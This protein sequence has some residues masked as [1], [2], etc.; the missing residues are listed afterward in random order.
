MRCDGS[1]RGNL[2]RLYRVRQVLADT[3]M[4]ERLD[5]MDPSELRGAFKAVLSA[6]QR[7]KGLDGFAWLGGLDAKA[8]D[9]AAFKAVRKRYW[10]ILTQAKGELPRTPARVDGRRGRVAKSDAQ[11]LHEALTK[12]E[13]EALRFARDPDV[14]FTNNRAERDI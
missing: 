2:C 9:G 11:N 12:R 6:L 5:R 10:T 7:G 8:L 3:T 13:D 4:R 14:H 1:V